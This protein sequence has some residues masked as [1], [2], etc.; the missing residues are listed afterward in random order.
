VWK[1]KPTQVILP[2]AEH[3]LYGVATVAGYRWLQ[4]RIES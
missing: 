2:V 1:Q 3:A 4:E